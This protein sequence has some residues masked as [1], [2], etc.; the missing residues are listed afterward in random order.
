MTE[1]WQGDILNEKLDIKKQNSLSH[2]TDQNE[3][4]IWMFLYSQHLQKSQVIEGK[5]GK[6]II[7]N[8]YCL[9]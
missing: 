3:M 7:C 2:Q 9:A 6:K 1:I 5:N 4:G 8:I